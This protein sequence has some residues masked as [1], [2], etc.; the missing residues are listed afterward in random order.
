MILCRVK[1]AHCLILM[2]CSIQ[3]HFWRRYSLILSILDQFAMGCIVLISVVAEGQLALL[4]PPEIPG[5]LALPELRVLAVPVLRATR[6][7][8][9][10]PDQLAQRAL[11]VAPKAIQEIPAQRV[12]RATLVQRE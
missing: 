10:K 12:T 7:T 6:E 2:G 9:D 11:L 4:A 1:H 3:R 8:Q 5:L